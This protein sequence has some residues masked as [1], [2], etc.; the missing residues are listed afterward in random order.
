MPATKGK[1][2]NTATTATEMARKII[3][4]RPKAL[5][6]REG[7]RVCYRRSLVS[8]FAEQPLGPYSDDHHS[9]EQNER[10]RDDRPD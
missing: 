2:Q 10:L 4:G 7:L 9:E 8:S 3:L 6:P 1:V 5:S